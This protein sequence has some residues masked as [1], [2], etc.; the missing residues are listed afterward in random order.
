MVYRIFVEHF[1]G[2][3]ILSNIFRELK[4][5]IQEVCEREKREWDKVCKALRSD[6]EK[7]EMLY[8]AYRR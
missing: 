5:S 2:G 3:D 6:V 7:Y 8:R 4:R 1:R